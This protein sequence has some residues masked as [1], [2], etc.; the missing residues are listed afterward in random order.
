MAKAK[1]PVEAEATTP[2]AP[3]TETPAKA[4]KGTFRVFDGRANL[5]AQVNDEAEAAQLAQ[6]HGGSY[7]KLN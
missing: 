2:V 1:A 6:E 3:V 4:T 7:T 5:V